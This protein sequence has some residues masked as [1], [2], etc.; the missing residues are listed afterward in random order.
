MVAAGT[1][2][3]R[4]AEYFTNWG[5]RMDAHAWGS[6]IVT[7][8][9]GD[10]YTLGTPQTEYTATFGGTSGA[11]PMLTGSALCL[12]GIA[13]ANLGVRLDPITLRALIHDTGVPHLDPT[14][15]IGPR[16]DLGA[17]SYYILNSAGVTQRGDRG[18][19]LRL[20]VAPNPTPAATEIL[21]AA[22]E[23]AE[24]SLALFDATGRCV[25][26][27]APRGASNGALCL[28][29]DG[30]DAAGRRLPSGVYYL[31]ARQGATEA[32]RA[33]LLTR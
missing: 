11:S 13:E 27:L 5:T 6:S 14:K 21:L 3:G 8:G 25:R 10:L 18:S 26:E 30:R 2:Y 29:W 7:T 16:P 17:A 1:P 9:Y 15:E 20:S 33:V 22:P 28:A 31:R 24:V 32:I 19:T 4:V 23:A 12:Q